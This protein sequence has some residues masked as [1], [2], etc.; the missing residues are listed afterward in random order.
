MNRAANK[1][2]LVFNAGVPCLEKRNRPTVSGWPVVL[3]A[4]FVVSRAGLEPATHW[5]KVAQT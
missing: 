3:H 1:K 2:N 5:L 4:L